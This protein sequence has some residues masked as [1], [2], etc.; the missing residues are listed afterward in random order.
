M[1]YYLWISLFSICE[2]NVELFVVSASYVGVNSWPTHA[3]HRTVQDSSNKK[4]LLVLS[5]CADNCM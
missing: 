3:I 4:F 2:D 5:S 1:L